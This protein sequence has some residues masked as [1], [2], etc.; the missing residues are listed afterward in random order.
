VTESGR[1]LAIFC[2]DDAFASLVLGDAHV[3][4]RIEDA[5]FA[6]LSLTVR[7]REL[8]ATGLTE[9]YR[10]TPFALE[11]FVDAVRVV[12]HAAALAEKD[13]PRFL[14][15]VDDR[16]RFDIRDGPADEIDG[17]AAKRRIAQVVRWLEGTVERTANGAEA[18]VNLPSGAAGR[19]V[20]D[21]RASTALVSGAVPGAYGVL[22]LSPAAGGLSRLWERRGAR[23]VGDDVIDGAWVVRGAGETA[24]LV[25]AREALERLAKDGARVRLFDEQVTIEVALDIGVRRAIDVLQDALEVWRLWEGSARE[26]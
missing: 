17:E 10:V 1:L 25:A 18:R 9:G 14:I 12:V 7:S 3:R 24:P 19:V 16:E 11:R 13:S 15:D 4:E 2:R 5:S 21:E 22:E 6:L 26:R 8:T 23:D 20:L